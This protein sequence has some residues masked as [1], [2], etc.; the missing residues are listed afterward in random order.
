[1]A[2]KLKQHIN[3]PKYVH[4]DMIYISRFHHPKHNC[5]PFQVCIRLSQIESPNWRSMFPLGLEDLLPAAA[6]QT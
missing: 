3:A 2:W 1:M 4:T 6:L 5:A